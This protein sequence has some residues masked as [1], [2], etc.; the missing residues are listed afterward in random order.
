[1]TGLP[2]AAGRVGAP[3]PAVSTF[4]YSVQYFINSHKRRPN[5]II[6]LLHRVLLDLLA[7]VV[8]LA[9]MDLV[10][11]VVTL[12][13]LVPLVSRGWLDHLVLLERR[14]H[15]ESLALL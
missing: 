7:P 2:G 11:S 1:M 8:L 15:L 14:D 10:V 4:F 12:A 5:I 13:L 6:L 9:K 3:G